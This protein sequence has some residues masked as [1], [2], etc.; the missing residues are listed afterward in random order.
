MFLFANISFSH[1][2]NTF[3]YREG[4]QIIGEAYFAD[5]SPCIKCRVEV[6]NKKGNKIFQTTTDEKG[7]YNFVLKEKG[8]FKIKVIAGEGHL[9]EFELEGIK[10]PESKSKFSKT[11]EEKKVFKAPKKENLY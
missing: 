3:A 10:E 1:K 11:S 4:N 8:F 5:G 9:A 6:Y 7:K 2:I